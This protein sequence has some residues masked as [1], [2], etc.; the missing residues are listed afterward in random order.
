LQETV[1]AQKVVKKT[2]RATGVE[3]FPE[4]SVEKSKKPTVK[5][6]RKVVASTAAAAASGAVTEPPGEL[7]KAPIIKRKGNIK[8]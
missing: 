8:L 5:R 4:D 6:I 7:V 3:G 2:L 1:K